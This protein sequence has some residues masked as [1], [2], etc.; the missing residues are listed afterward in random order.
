MTIIEN[1]AELSEQEQRTFAEA[2]MKTINSEH[3]FTGE[4]DLKIT[5]V[6]A[7]EMDGGLWIEATNTDPIEVSRKATWQAGEDDVYSPD[8]DLVNYTDSIYTEVEQTLKTKEVTIGDYIVTLNEV[9][10]V[11]EEIEDVDVDS[12]SH[13]DSGIGSYEYWGE[14]GYDSHPYVEAEGTIT[15]ECICDFVFH[16]DPVDEP[17][18]EEP[19][20][21]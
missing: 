3:I 12:M 21:D 16:V 17:A 5:N 18:V 7:D 1:F 6:E 11:D 20:E 4:S 2:L 19:E 10:N 14:V 9:Y 8:P 15:V 13:E